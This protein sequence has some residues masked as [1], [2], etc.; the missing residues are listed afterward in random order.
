MKAIVQV[1]YG[2]PDDL[3]LREVESPVVGDGEVLAKLRLIPPSRR[4]SLPAT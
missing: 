1:R 3:E 2:S 4:V